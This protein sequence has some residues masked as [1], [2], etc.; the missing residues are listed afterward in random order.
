MEP[1]IK[2]ALCSFGMSGKLFHAPFID[3]H[4]GFEL[5]AVWER[6][7]SIVKEVYPRTVSYKT[8]E[9]LLNDDEIQ[10]VVVNTPNITHYEY[11]KKCLLAGK[12]VIVEKPF[13]VNSKEAEE[14]IELAKEK[15]RKLSVY[16]NR[17]WDSDFKTIKKVLDAGLL[18]KLVDVELHYDR[19]KKE[20]SPKV[21]KEVPTPG[22][23]VL[24]DLG[25]HLIDTAL[26]LFGK[27]YAVFADLRKVRPVTEINDHMDVILFYPEMRVRLKSGYLAKEP[28]PSFIL[29]GVQG[30]FLKP[31]TD[32]QEMDL[33]NG[34]KPGAKDWGKEPEEEKGFIHYE[35]Q[36][37]TVVKEKII[38]EK[39]NYMDY[40]DGI[41]K[42]IV[43]NAPLPVTAEEG[44]LVMNIIDAAIE[45]NKHK[46]LI[47]I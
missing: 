5:R 32:V 7:K 25:S 8:L 29:H 26:Q 40:F 19:Y 18:G 1:K 37:G 24:H 34:K 46:K 6:S 30:S 14:L 39:G 31:R 17:R 3:A 28:V 22:A 36:D 12:D 33:Q 13:T 10:L 43:E 16:H 45:S 15:G 44:L 2:V 21:H 23:G 41:Y 47:E 11:T 38:S 27:P 20:L 9:D 42:A 35:L 4:P